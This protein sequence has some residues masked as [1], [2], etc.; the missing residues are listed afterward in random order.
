MAKH[1]ASPEACLITDLGLGTNGLILSAAFGMVSAGVGF[2]VGFA[3]MV[4][5]SL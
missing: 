3:W 2:A 4:G 1:G 5:Q